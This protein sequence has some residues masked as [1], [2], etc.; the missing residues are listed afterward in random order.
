M[1]V[2]GE[3]WM[4]RHLKHLRRLGEDVYMI[5]EARPFRVG[6]GPRGMSMYAVNI[7][8]NLDRASQWAHL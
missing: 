2:A 6:T 4:R 1:T 5:D 7:P 3:K 8:I